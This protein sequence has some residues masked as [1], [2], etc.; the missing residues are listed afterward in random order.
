MSIVCKCYTNKRNGMEYMYSEN[1][2]GIVKIETKF[3]GIA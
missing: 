3:V 1:F 2:Q